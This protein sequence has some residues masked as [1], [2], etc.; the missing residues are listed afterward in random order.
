[1][2]ADAEV[3]QVIRTR[4]LRRGN[5]STTPIRIIEQFWSLDGELLAEVDPCPDEASVLRGSDEQVAA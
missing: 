4:L 1:M 2:T 3:I 5:G